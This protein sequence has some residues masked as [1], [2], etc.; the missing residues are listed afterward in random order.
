MQRAGRGAAE[1]I[2]GWLDAQPLAAPAVDGEIL[3]LCGPGNNGGD[4]YACAA[5]LRRLGHR[6]VCWAARPGKR[7]DALAARARWSQDGGRIVADLPPAQGVRLVVDALF[8]IGMARPLDDPFLG[9][10]RWAQAQA[11][12]LV[13]L[14][15][16]SGLDPDTGA[17]VGGVAGAPARLTI[18]FLG[19]KPGLHTLEGIDAA[20]TIVLDR[21]GVDEPDGAA[22]AGAVRAMG[23]L[24]EPALFPLAL[25]RR[26]SN[27]N[28]GDF[29]SVA[30]VGGATGMVGAVLLAGRAALRLGAG[31]VYV[32]ALGAPDLGVD[33]LQPELMLRP[34]AAD[35]SYATPADVVVAGC[36]MGTDAAAERALHC[37]LA[38]PGGLVLDADA[39][40]LIGAS[41][42][43]R[44]RVRARAPGTTILTPHPGEAARLLG[45]STAQVQQDRVARALELAQSCAALVVLKGAGSVI[46]LAPAPGAAQG[47]YVINPTGGPALSSAGT[48]DVLA[49]MIG[50]LLGQFV[51][52]GDAAGDGFAP[53]AAPVQATLAA[54]WLHGRAA[55]DHGA[56]LGLAASDIALLA[57]RALQRLRDA[58]AGDARP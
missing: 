5:A 1:A 24:N 42:A 37:A 34:A 46:A 32:H 29:G 52:G 55:Q 43:L 6:C 23:R 40:N 26:P 3:V 4:G 44:Q 53:A 28:K 8:G 16:P 36:G 27:A 11:L 45:V 20:G 35:G 31:K 49:G 15:L 58:P 13:A 21:L 57:A 22:P 39:L 30:I 7:T 2:H 25:Q 50:A 48:G 12:P 47:H 19:D 17:W 41:A 51:R 33:P 9:A 18:T 10:L 14:D 38:H 54:V 56:Q